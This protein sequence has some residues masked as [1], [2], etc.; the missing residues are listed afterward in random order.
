MQYWLTLTLIH[1]YLDSLE[2][3]FF[4]INVYN[5]FT[6]SK[7]LIKTNFYIYMTR[8]KIINYLPN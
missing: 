2:R 4:F 7:Y 8:V 5:Y 1:E 6:E 3:C